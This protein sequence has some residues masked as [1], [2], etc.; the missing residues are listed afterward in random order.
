[1][2]QVTTEAAARPMMTA[3]TTVSADTNMPHGERSRGSAA[4]PIT[5][6]L[7]SA[8]ACAQATPASSGHAV[9]KPSIARPHRSNANCRPVDHAAAGYEP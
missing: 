7:G 1:M 8:G 4:V 5:G 3:F 9:A 6:A 2:V